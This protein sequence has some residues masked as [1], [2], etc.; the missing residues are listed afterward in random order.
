MELTL[1]KVALCWL[2]VLLNRCT[3]EDVCTL[4]YLWTPGKHTRIPLIREVRARETYHNFNKMY[5]RKMQ[6][7]VLLDSVIARQYSIDQNRLAGAIT[8]H[9]DRQLAP[10]IWCDVECIIYTTPAVNNGAYR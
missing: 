6:I 4:V 2:H 3:E 1:R 7:T 10:S 9:L 8:A 5:V